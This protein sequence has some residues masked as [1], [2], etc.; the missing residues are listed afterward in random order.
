VIKS[1][2]WGFK[3][4]RERVSISG[5]RVIFS[6]SLSLSLSSVGGFS[7]IKRSGGLGL[8]RGWAGP[9]MDRVRVNRLY[10]GVRGACN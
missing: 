9:R 6:L 7:G 2:S 10:G 4:D 1:V 5:R 8:A 3:I